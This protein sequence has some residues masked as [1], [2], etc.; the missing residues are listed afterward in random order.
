VK[1]LE[2]PRGRPGKETAS[3][4]HTE[5]SL[6]QAT[7]LLPGHVADI[8]DAYCVVAITPYDRQRRRVFLSLHSAVQAVERSRKRGLPAELILCKLVPVQADL[9][10]DGEVTE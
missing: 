2:V 9:D 8:A 3:T 1:F 7:E 10:L 5:T 4:D 6:T